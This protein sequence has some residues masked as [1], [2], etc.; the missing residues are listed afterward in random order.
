MTLPPVWGAPPAG[1]GM[2]KRSSTQFENASPVKRNGCCSSPAGKTRVRAAGALQGTVRTGLG[3]GVG[4]VGTAVAAVAVAVAV[5]MAGGAGRLRDQAWAQT[6]RV[7]PGAPP[8][9]TAPPSP[10][11]PPPPTG[12]IS[13]PPPP[14]TP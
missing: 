6:T 10:P 12:L 8:K 14:P 7:A 5:A 13:G 4:V 2:T 1:A 11:P 9:E 3:A